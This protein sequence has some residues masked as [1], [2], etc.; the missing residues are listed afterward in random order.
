MF[1]MV[2]NVLEYT[3]YM[4]QCTHLSL[5][6]PVG[7]IVNDLRSNITQHHSVWKS[8]KMSHL[9]FCILAFS[10][11]FCPLEFPC[12]VALVFKNSPK[13]TILGIF[14]QLLSTQNLA[15]FAC[16]VE[17]DFFCDFQTLWTFTIRKVQ[18]PEIRVRFPLTMTLLRVLQKPIV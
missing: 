1:Q 4:Y 17:C 9:S 14:N 13:L 11:N 10:V 15:R 3:Q 6:M 2:P 8:S 5:T 7:D 18:F 16:N 12:L